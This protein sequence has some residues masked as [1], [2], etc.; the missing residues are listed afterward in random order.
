MYPQRVGP[1]MLS[2]LLTR[3]Q[4]NFS[5]VPIESISTGTDKKPKLQEIAAGKK[6]GRKNLP[7]VEQCRP[8]RD[9]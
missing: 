4:L 2:A 6:C 3:L 1:K 9:W 7:N 5:P 8:L